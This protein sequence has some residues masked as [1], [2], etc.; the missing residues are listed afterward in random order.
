VIAFCGY[1]NTDLT[2]SVPVLPGAGARVQATAVD[3]RDGGMAANAA[4]AAA[5]AGADARFA[6]VVGADRT[7]AAFLDALGADGVDTSWTALTGMLT[8][9][10]VLVTPDGE[11]SIISQDDAVTPDHVRR[12][13]FATAAVG[14]LLCLDGYR[15]PAAADAL[16]DTTVRSLVD[17]DGCEDPD[18][19]HRALDT[20]DHVIVGRDQAARLFGD[21]DHTTLAAEYDVHLAVT[22][23]A[24]GWWLHTPTGETH[25]GRALEVAVVDATGA[26]DCFTGSYCAELDGGAT[27]AAAATFAGIAAGLS[28]TRPG[29]RA[30]SPRRSEVL[31]LLHRSPTSDEE[32]SCA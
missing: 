22:G 12:I 16:V 27:P 5:R 29:A 20:V 3:W 18:A 7:S 1:A 15:F 31:D 13:A 21:A 2:V 8:T 32:T 6:G 28:C 14:G 23:G 17:L 10:I 25:Y 4:V 11:R 19:A 30:G 26:G 24:L 9:A